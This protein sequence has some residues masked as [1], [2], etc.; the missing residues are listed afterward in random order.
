MR[1]IYRHHQRKVTNNFAQ[2]KQRLKV[3]DEREK[4]T[5][6]FTESD[7]IQTGKVTRAGIPEHFILGR[8]FFSHFFQQLFNLRFESLN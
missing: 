5:I 8:H 3:E 7:R 6:L 2:Q 1:R 4:K